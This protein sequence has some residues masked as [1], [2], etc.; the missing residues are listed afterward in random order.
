MSKRKNR[1]Y[2]NRQSDVKKDREKDI[3]LYAEALYLAMKKYDEESKAN[4]YNIIKD[5]NEKEK[6]RQVRTALRTVFLPFLSNKK[7]I[8]HGKIYIELLGWTVSIVIR[9]LGW[10]I[11]IIGILIII[12]SFVK[13]NHIGLLSAIIL[14]FMGI[15]LLAI[16]GSTIFAGRKFEEDTDSTDIYAYTSSIIALLSF[17]L[18]IISL[19]I[20]CR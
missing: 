16:G 1:K 12:A 17:I 9:F 19:V 15:G 5:T 8:T 6:P 10:I 11:W 14:V 4:S 20:S 7:I 2:G 18:A 13:M 3:E